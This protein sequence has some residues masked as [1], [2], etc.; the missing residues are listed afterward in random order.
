VTPEGAY[1]FALFRRADTTDVCWQGIAG[2]GE[3]DET[4]EAAAR[5][6]A[7]EE[8]GIAK[9]G[10]LLPLDSRAMIPVQAICGFLWGQDVL[11]IPEF[12]F[13]IA[14]GAGTGELR[15]SGEHRECRWAPYEPARDLLRWDSNRVALWELNHRLLRNR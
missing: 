10:P 7:F 15:L 12:C 8:A 14:I 3:D 9:D 2:G 1:E 11:V 6:E 13:G 4:P 5:R